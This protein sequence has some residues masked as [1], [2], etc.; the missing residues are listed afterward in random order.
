MLSEI[1]FAY[2]N[3]GKIDSNQEWVN[4]AFKLKQKDKRYALEIIEDWQVGRVAVI[5]CVPWVTSFLLG[6]IWSACGGDVQTAFT[7]ASFVLTAGSSKSWTF[8]GETL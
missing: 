1:I 2:L 3:P 7:V 8:R 4:W 5:G 6:I